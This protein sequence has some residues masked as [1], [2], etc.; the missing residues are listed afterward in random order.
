MGGVKW[1]VHKFQLIKNCVFQIKMPSERLCRAGAA[2][3]GAG[4]GA[5]GGGGVASCY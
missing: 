4:G 3:G 2:R 1:G 5:G